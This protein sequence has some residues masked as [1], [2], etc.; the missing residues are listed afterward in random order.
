MGKI[1]VERFWN[2]FPTCSQCNLTKSDKTIELEEKIAQRISS[3]LRTWLIYFRDHKDEFITLVGKEVQHI[4]SSFI[5][6]AIDFLL[7]HLKYI[8]SNLV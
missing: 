3:Y 2:L 8:I 1:P 4:E 7:E 5:D 6:K